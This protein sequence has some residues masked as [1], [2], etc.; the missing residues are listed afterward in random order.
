MRG[1]RPPARHGVRLNT[2]DQIHYNKN[3]VI[4]LAIID[5]RGDDNWKDDTFTMALQLRPRRRSAP[6]P[7]R[8]PTV[9]IA[10]INAA[11]RREVL[12]G[13]HRVDRANPDNGTTVMVATGDMNPIPAP[14]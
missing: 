14:S 13:Q 6:R 5:P 4:R 3:G 9:T 8:P 10:D 12:A 7:V 11:R 2:L 1:S